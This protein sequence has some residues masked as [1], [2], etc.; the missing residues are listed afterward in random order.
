[1]EIKNAT[2][3]HRIWKTRPD[4]ELLAT[5]QYD[6]D[7]ETFCKAGIEDQPEGTFLV[8]VSHYS[9][10]MRCIHKAKAE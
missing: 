1:M 10:Q 4:A 8:Y 7:A 9:G 2:T 3:V 6:R 5:F